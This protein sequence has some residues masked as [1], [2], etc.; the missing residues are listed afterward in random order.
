MH[1]K[2][3]NCIDVNSN[4]WVIEIK[5][6]KLSNRLEQSGEHLEFYSEL[7]TTVC[8]LLVVSATIVVSERLF[9]AVRTIKS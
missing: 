8:L 7:C 9:S 2:M 1:Q 3:N 5:T 4:A 6:L